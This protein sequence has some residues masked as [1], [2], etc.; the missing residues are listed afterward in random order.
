MANP[1]ANQKSV[2]ATVDDPSKRPAPAGAD[3]RGRWYQRPSD[4]EWV[5]RVDNIDPIA[6]PKPEVLVERQAKAQ[7]E[8][9]AKVMPTPQDVEDEQGDVQAKLA[10]GWEWIELPNGKRVLRKQHAQPDLRRQPTDAEIVSQLQAGKIKFPTENEVRANVM[11][12]ESMR[13]DD[14]RLRV[15]PEAGGNPFMPKL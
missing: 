5:W 2:T 13:R 15:T 14:G 4:G 6:P 1:N 10:S 7:A 3:P 8:L 12:R 9:R 11:A